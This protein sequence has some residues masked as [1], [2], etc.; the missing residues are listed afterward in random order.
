MEVVSK[1]YFISVKIEDLY[2]NAILQ[3]IFLINTFF[4]A[5]E[6]DHETIAHL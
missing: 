5:L 3:E 4:I 2:K 6:I 1:F